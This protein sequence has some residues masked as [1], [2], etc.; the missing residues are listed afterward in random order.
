MKTEAFLSKEMKRSGR[1]FVHPLNVH[2]IGFLD[3]IR[4]RTGEGREGERYTSVHLFEK[5]I[6][7]SAD[8]HLITVLSSSVSLVCLLLLGYLRSS[9]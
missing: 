2:T 5:K 3:I 1:N 6:F 4:A 9:I 8:F 7:K